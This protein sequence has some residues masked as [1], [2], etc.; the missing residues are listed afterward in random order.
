MPYIKFFNLVL[1]CFGFMAINAQLPSTDIY[2]FDRSGSELSNPKLLTGFNDGYNSQAVFFNDS[3]IYFTADWK[4]DDQTDI[5]K[6]DIRKEEL[7]RITA[8]EESEYSP[9]PMPDGNNFSVVRVEKDDRKSQVLWKYPKNRTTT[10]ESIL[11]DR[12]QI[13]YYEWL[14]VSKIALFMVGEPH[15]LVIYDNIRG[16]YKTVATDVGRCLRQFK[17]KLIFVQKTPSAWFIKEYN[18][19]TQEIRIICST[20]PNSEDFA[21]SSD[22]VLWMAAESKIYNR[23]INATQ[24]WTLVKNTN[25]LNLNKLHRVEISNNN[26]IVINTND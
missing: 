6:F 2:L 24:N 13:G 1:C 8:T 11:F 14:G 22:G 18:P 25:E 20:L 26:L 17:G 10:G 19:V 3:E 23:A 21:I 16:G 15:K 7:L 9:K 12:D 5:F 4:N